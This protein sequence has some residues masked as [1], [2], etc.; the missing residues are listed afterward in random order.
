MLQM[1]PTLQ[2]PNLAY[3]VNNSRA[4]LHLIRSKKTLTISCSLSRNTRL[5]V[6]GAHN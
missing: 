4:R 1:S 6:G 5:N 3:F 2:V